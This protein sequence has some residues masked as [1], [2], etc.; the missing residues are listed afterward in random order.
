MRNRAIEAGDPGSPAGA[1][2]GGLARGGV[3]GGLDRREFIGIVTTLVGGSLSL[4]CTRMLMGDPPEGVSETAASSLVGERRA[5][6]E[7]ACERILPA[8]ETPGAIDAGVPDFVDWMVTAWYDADERARFLAGVDDLDARARSAAGVGFAGAGPE[9]QDGILET[10]QAETSERAG[11]PMFLRRR[12]PQTFFLAL[13]ELTIVGF[14][15]SEVGA[16]QVLEWQAMPGR[17]D[18][19]APV[20]SLGRASAGW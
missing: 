7:A 1:D 12:A 11:A 8:T 18:A 20:A 10:L 5:I 3:P 2:R 13:K 15:T 4:G 14:C 17:F 19:C 6:V 9:V 16:T